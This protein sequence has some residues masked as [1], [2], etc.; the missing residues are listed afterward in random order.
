MTMRDV[1]TWDVSP[2]EAFAE[3]YDDY[4][5][6]IYL[7]ILELARAFAPRIEAWMKRNAPWKDRT[8]NARQSLYTEIEATLLSIAISMDHGVEYGFW[9]EYANAGT[10]S[11][12]GPALDFWAVQ[13]WNAVKDLVQAK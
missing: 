11:I 1:F 13:F 9:L 3:L 10:Y 7:G 5:R 6:R 4:T 8:S 2:D 12:I